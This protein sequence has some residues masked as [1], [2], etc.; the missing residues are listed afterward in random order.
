MLSR[1]QW[2]GHINF[3]SPSRRN[4]TFTGDFWNDKYETFSTEIEK[5]D[6]LGHDDRLEFKVAKNMFTKSTVTYISGL[7]CKNDSEDYKLV[8]PS[9]KSNL[10]SKKPRKLIP[11]IVKLKADKR[12]KSRKVK[13]DKDYKVD[14]K[15]KTIM[16]NWRRADIEQTITDEPT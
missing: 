4:Y 14:T 12:I 6:E 8:M 3:K 5:W 2:Q 1:G 13:I 10:G 9:T 15:S 7:S 16:R 11:Q